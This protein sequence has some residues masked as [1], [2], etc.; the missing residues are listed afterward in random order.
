MALRARKRQGGGSSGTQFND[1]KNP[2]RSTTGVG[3]TNPPRASVNA[4]T[5]PRIA[6]TVASP[7][8][9]PPSA[10]YVRK[11]A[12]AATIPTPG[13][14]SGALR[15]NAAT[16]LGI[17]QGQNRDAIFRAVMQLGDP[18]QFAQYAADPRFA[19]YQFT[20]DPNSVF[21]SLGRQETRGLEDIDAG[22]N[23][24]N[25]FFSGMRLRDRKNLSD[26]TGRQR[27]AGSTSFLDDLKS[28]AASLGGSEGQ[29]RQDMADADQM[30][31]DAAL[32]KDREAREEWLAGGGGAAPIAPASGS[33]L[34]P[35]PQ[36][37]RTTLATA[38]AKARAQEQARQQAAREAAAK[39]KAK[40]K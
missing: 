10:T 39:K 14:S 20:Q 24:G 32:A 8:V 15:A 31:I 6:P 16:N 29:F 25:T 22:A 33:P 3:S 28:F 36:L 19:G 34:V 27:L 37:Q 5:R 7:V 23:V 17:A 21:A 26:E 1:P 30:D 9:T 40:K 13:A 11:P 4:P 35:P 12:P 18:T 38:Q 2:N